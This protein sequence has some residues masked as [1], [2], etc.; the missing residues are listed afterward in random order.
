MA[1]IICRTQHTKKNRSRK[2]N[3]DKDK[4]AFYNLMNNVECGKT[5]EN[6]CKF[7]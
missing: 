7:L 5:M 6:R 4:K 1:K 2:K 3:G